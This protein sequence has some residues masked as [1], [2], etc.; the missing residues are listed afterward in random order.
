MDAIVT[1]LLQEQA[2]IIADGHLI[3]QMGNGII[4][5]GAVLSGVRIA[6]RMRM[7]VSSLRVRITHHRGRARTSV[8]G[9]PSVEKLR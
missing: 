2:L 9:L 6:V 3:M 8:L 4:M 7:A 1:S 5:Q